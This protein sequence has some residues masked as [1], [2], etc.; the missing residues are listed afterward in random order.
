MEADYFLLRVIA[1]DQDQETRWFGHM[2]SEDVMRRASRYFEAR[3]RGH[4]VL[5]FT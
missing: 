1:T 4:T 3:T 2:S 5:S